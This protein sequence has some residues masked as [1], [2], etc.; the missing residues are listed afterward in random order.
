MHKSNI[1]HI[2]YKNN[3]NVM[4]TKYQVYLKG[5]NKTLGL[6]LGLDQKQIFTVKDCRP[7]IQTNNF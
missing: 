5:S 1:I 2:S 7:L 3:N 6:L 4:Y